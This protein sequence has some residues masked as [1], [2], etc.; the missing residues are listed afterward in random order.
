VYESANN[1]DGWIIK[2]LDELNRNYTEYH[3]MNLLKEDILAF[4]EFCINEYH[5][6]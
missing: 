5:T 1:I 2:N 3:F 6:Q 4:S